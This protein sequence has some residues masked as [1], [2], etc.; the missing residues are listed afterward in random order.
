MYPCC[1][2]IHVLSAQKVFVFGSLA[3]EEHVQ[4]FDALGAISKALILLAF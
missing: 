1:V 4:L 3:R 2:V